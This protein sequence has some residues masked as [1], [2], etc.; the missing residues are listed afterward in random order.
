[1][2]AGLPWAEIE[3]VDWKRPDRPSPDA[4]WRVPSERMK[5]EFDMREDDE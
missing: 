2:V 3:G 4:L 1:M 5:V